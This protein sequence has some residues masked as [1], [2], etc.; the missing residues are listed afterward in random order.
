ME[1]EYNFQGLKEIALRDGFEK[2]TSGFEVSLGL[3]ARMFINFPEDHPF[4]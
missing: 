2:R 3:E 4:M 1:V